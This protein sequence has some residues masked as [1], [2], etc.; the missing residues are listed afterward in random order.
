MISVEKIEALIVKEFKRQ[1]N[2]GNLGY[3]VQEE[4]SAMPHEAAVDGNI[5]TKELAE[6]LFS[7]LVQSEHVRS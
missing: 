2:H 4:V 3:Y 7:A 5:N 1:F 6:R